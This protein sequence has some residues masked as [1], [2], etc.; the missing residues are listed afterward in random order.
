MSDMN[1]NAGSERESAP[2]SP[3]ALAERAGAELLWRLQTTQTGCCVTVVDRDGTVLFANAVA[4]AWFRWREE[5]APSRPD[6]PRLHIAQAC[7]PGM[8]SERL[9]YFR[10]VCDEG[11]A[12]AYESINDGLRELVYLCPM[13]APHREGL[14]V[15]TVSRRLR[16]W[17]RV[18]DEHAPGAII[19][20]PGEHEPGR[21]GLLSPRELEVLV[22]VGEGYSYA[23]IGEMLHRSRRTIER[24]RDGICAKLGVATRLE[25]ARFAIRAGLASMCQPH[26]HAM[27][28]Q[29]GY[30]PL[31]V[32]EAVAAIA[33]RRVR[34]Q[35]D[36]P[37]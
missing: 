19:V 26:E 9:D 2:V 8:A 13:P 15:L 5:H 31:N 32:S 20:H 24:H 11:A 10:R 35:V 22:L 36:E 6:M 16:S 4:L 37:R 14:V 18:T 7:T 30:D 25:I 3:G 21:L 28:S 29:A 12:L 33:H 17:E 1:L 27:L 34:R 23:E